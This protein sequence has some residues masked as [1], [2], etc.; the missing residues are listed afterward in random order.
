MLL[1]KRSSVQ[2]KYTSGTTFAFAPHCHSFLCSFLTCPPQ[3]DS[4]SRLCSSFLTL[5]ATTSE[6]Q[7]TSLSGSGSG[8]AVFPFPWCTAPSS[9]T[10]GASPAGSWPST[11]LTLTTAGPLTTSWCLPSRP[12]RPVSLLENGRLAGKC[13]IQ[14]AAGQTTALLP[15]F[16]SRTL[17]RASAVHHLGR[18]RCTLAFM[19][20]DTCWTKWN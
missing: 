6:P 12:G 11:L 13:D 10:C 2:F 18:T 19:S 9:W 20:H 3:V 7:T 4:R 8:S 17:K 5:R 15:L 1:H 16:V 14:G